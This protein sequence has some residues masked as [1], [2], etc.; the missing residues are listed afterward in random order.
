MAAGA[1]P[2][3]LAAC[4]MS[5]S[6]RSPSNS[7][8]SLYAASG[9]SAPPVHQT[10]RL[11]CADA[12]SAG[13]PADNAGLTFGGITLE[14]LAGNIVGSFPAE[15][16]LSVPAGET[17]YFFKTPAW[18][19]EG[20]AAT[21]ELSSASGGYLAWVPARI[22][23]G[24]NRGRVDLTPWLTSKLVFDGCPDRDSTYFGG[25]LSTDP[26]ICLKLQ[27]AVGSGKSRQISVGSA[28]QC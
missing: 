5:S 24:G 12:G 15:V 13:E 25:L 2:L 27:I 18:L 7:A 28:T 21:I 6:P 16:G 20:V 10:V 3:V 1:A 4:T 26:N 8:T 11:S 17:L 14:G 23:T 19:K 9:P 22:W